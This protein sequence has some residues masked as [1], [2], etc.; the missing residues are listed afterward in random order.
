MEYPLPAEN[1]P[2]YCFG[3]QIT[4]RL[5]KKKWTVKDLANQMTEIAKT[6]GS[7]DAFTKTQIDNWKGGRNLPNSQAVLD[8]LAE[9]L[10]IDLATLLCIVLPTDKK[11]AEH[12][13]LV[14]IIEDEKRYKD[15][16][17]KV[18][19]QTEE[20][21]WIQLRV[22]PALHESTMLFR[23]LW[24]K[25]KPHIRLRLLVC[26]PN[27]PCTMAMVERRSYHW[28]GEADIPASE[29]ANDLKTLAG[30]AAQ[31]K[32]KSKLQIKVLSYFPSTAIYLS[33]PD[34]KNGKL[35]AVTANYG[36]MTDA[37]KAPV[38]IASSETDP[39]IFNFYRKQFELLWKDAKNYRP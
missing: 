27:D 30:V 7:R 8:L 2:F 11:T 5:N 20:E 25:K 14:S 33:D 4:T 26:D 32:A 31:E 19:A 36:K 22:T 16:R 12:S 13:P 23:Q 3:A 28:F 21:L 34:T 6:R 24:R 17:E 9:I 37:Y 29:I 1:A 35:F 39:T 10:E 38:T 15:E 18:V